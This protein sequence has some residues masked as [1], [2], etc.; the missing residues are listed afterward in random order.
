MTTTTAT[1]PA[2]DAAR[3]ELI[4]TRLYTPVLGDVL[5][6]L[7]RCHQFLP[8]GIVALRSDLV[9][10][11][12]AMP[13]LVAPV[14]GPQARPFG[15]LTEALDQLASGEVYVAQGAG[16][17]AAAWGEI[18]TATARMRGAT[19]AVIDGFHRDT[20]QILAQDWPVY[21]R[22]GYA[23]DSSVRSAILDYRVPIEIATTAVRPGDLI[24][25][26]RDGVLVIPREVED[27][28]LER[29]LTKAGAEN[30]V[31]NAILDG[32]SSTDAFTRYGV[33]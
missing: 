21:S 33:L 27:E 16:V 20:P 4:R 23:Q 14:Y 11:G 6:A 1:L 8:P 18:L 3:F 10:V 15:K 28:V 24:V 22:G 26:D 25:G 5:D 12:R 17:P 13:V 7:G 19:G 30:V 9:V 29:A 31:L 2:D 32:M